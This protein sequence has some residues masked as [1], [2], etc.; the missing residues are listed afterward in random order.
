MPY[1]PVTL[2]PHLPSIHS[3]PLRTCL[4][5]RGDTAVQAETTGERAAKS[6]YS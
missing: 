4:Q 6:T 3:R 1:F 5:L 2:G